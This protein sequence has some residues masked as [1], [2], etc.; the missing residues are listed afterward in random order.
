M[1][2]DKDSEI[3]KAPQRVEKSKVVQNLSGP[4]SVTTRLVPPSQNK[5]SDLKP[6]RTSY[7][8]VDND[9]I[10]VMVNME[11]QFGVEQRQ[12]APLLAYIMNK[13]AGQNWETPTE[14]SESE[15]CDENQN[16]PKLGKRKKMKDL[17][18]VLPS[19]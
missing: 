13:L 2:V 7:K 5:T 10:E 19:R 3:F 8:N 4:S 1:E 11:S 15:E 6:V 14:E 9:I 18:F 16:D 17:T 12:V